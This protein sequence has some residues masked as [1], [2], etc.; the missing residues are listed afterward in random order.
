MHQ[1][2]DR[3]RLQPFFQHR[4]RHFGVFRHNRHG[5]RLD[6]ELGGFQV[7]RVQVMIGRGDVIQDLLN[8]QYHRQIVG[9][10]LLVQAGNTG[11]IASADGGFSR[12]HLLPVQS[13]NVFDRL[14]GKSLHAAGILGDQQN[15]KTCRRF[16]AGHCGQVDNRDHLVTNID[17]PH[18]G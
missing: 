7:G 9:I 10:R 4:T 13:H 5:T 12:M 15:V 1:R 6:I 3:H 2:R 17:H 8:V 11:D 18:Q 14:D 16:A